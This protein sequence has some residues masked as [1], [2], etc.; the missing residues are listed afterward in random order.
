LPDL[1]KPKFNP[2]ARS[3]E[4]V[5]TY[6]ADFEAAHALPILRPVQVN[7]VQNNG[8]NLLVFTSQGPWRT[9]ALI[10][11]TGTWNNPVLPVYPGSESFTGRQL[12]TRD[13]V[14]AQEFAGLRV[15]IV[16]GGISAI[17]HLEEIS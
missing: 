5:S 3:A 6:F 4:A 10:N 8:P 12:H 7:A 11:A 16:G 2:Q 9:S 1:P 15:A 17:Q 14:S 13:Y